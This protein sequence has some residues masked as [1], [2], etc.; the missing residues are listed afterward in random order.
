MQLLPWP[1][2]A[3]PLADYPS[4]LLT[5]GAICMYAVHICYFTL[6]TLYT[7]WLLQIA[8]PNLK[9]PVTTTNEALDYRQVSTYACSRPRTVVCMI[10]TRAVSGARRCR[11]G[12]PCYECESRKYCLRSR[13]CWPYHGYIRYPG[14][15]RYDT[16]PTTVYTR[17]TRYV[18]VPHSGY[19]VVY[20]QVAY[21]IPL[22]IKRT[23]SVCGREPYAI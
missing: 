17:Y 12:I 6:R 21:M 2:L 1:W 8:M 4:H 16:S 7:N 11:I 15:T 23:N 19:P 22:L 18:P 3:K 10:C 20:A 5:R 13:P 9:P 14:T